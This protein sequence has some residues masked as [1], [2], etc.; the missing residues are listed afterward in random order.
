MF[1]SPFQNYLVINVN[2]SHIW[3]SIYNNFKRNSYR[4][5]SLNSHTSEHFI[6]S[7]QKLARLDKEARNLNASYW[8]QEE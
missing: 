7:I 8:L 6:H 4:F 3:N 1:I 2:T 5:L